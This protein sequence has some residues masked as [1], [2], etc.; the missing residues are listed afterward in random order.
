MAGSKSAAILQ[1]LNET[2]KTKPISILEKMLSKNE[3][4]VSI[5]NMVKRMQTLYGFTFINDKL[6]LTGFLAG[7]VLP[8]TSIIYNLVFNTGDLKRAMKF[9][10]VAEV[11]KEFWLNELSERNKVAKACLSYLQASCE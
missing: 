9:T 8:M 6:R 10:S 11:A 7:L 1:S 4:E 2:E 5:N 3:I